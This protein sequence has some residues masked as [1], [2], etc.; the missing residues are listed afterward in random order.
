MMIIQGYSFCEPEA[1]PKRKKA[2][3]TKAFALV[4]M[5]VLGCGLGTPE[6]VADIDRHREETVLCPVFLNYIEG[7]TSDT[8]KSTHS[9]RDAIISDLN[10]FFTELNYN[11]W[12]GYG[13]H[14]I[15]KAACDNAI[16]IINQTPEHILKL[17][18]VFP[19]PNGTISFEFKAREVAMMSIG[20]DGFSFAAMKDDEDPIMGEMDFD[21]E[22]AS[23]SLI[24]MSNLFGS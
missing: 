15:Q 24:K 22:Q 23:E 11:G 9:E 1:L 13:A 7:E 20:V 5:T 17:W 12:D 4:G 10:K 16:S 8:A 18:N 6:A 21:A 14:P 2:G 3:V 19:A